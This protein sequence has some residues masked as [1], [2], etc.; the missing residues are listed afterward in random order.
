MLCVSHSY[1]HFFVFTFSILHA[2]LLY[3][4]QNSG[5]QWHA[6]NPIITNRNWHHL[7]KLWQM[8]G[9]VIVSFFFQ[10]FFFSLCLFCYGCAI[11]KNVTADASKSK[12]EKVDLFE[13]SGIN[14]CKRMLRFIDFD[15]ET[16]KKWNNWEKCKRKIETQ[17][18]KSNLVVRTN[19]RNWMKNSQKSRS[20]NQKL[21][22]TQLK[23]PQQPQQYQTALDGKRITC[24]LLFFFHF[25][26]KCEFNQM[27][28][29]MHR[30]SPKLHNHR[31]HHHHQHQHIWCRHIQQYC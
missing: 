3:R 28:K 27:R 20:I 2:F 10:I 1:T 18:M 11:D 25:N 15:D 7:G 23:Q 31:H 22:N 12:T 14:K 19:T 4:R 9:I 13:E 30:Q 29:Q 5:T 26:T 6:I 21:A 8:T 16:R 24:D 17:K